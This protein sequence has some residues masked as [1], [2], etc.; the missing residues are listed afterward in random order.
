MSRISIRY[1]KALFSLAQDQKKLDKVADDLSDLKGLL[2]SSDDFNKFVLNP[3]ISGN[4]KAEILKSL[5]SGKLDPLTLDFLYLLSNK[6]RVNVLDEILLKFDALLLKHRN[7]I[8]AELTSPSAL[9]DKQ[10]DLIKTNI[11]TMTQKSV[12]LET[13]EDASLIG[14]FTVKIDDI[15]IDNSVRYQLFK[16][17]EKLI[18]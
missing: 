3:L 4:K 1:A 11:E 12:L 15:V 9:D 18:S 10:L 8:V 14:G 6:K 2:G 17:K 16:L 13:K 5:F 7:Q